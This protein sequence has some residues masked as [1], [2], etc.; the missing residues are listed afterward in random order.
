MKVANTGTQKYLT[1][2]KWNDI[3]IKTIEHI[4]PQKNGGYWD[5]ALYT[6]GSQLVQS[7]GNLTLLPTAINS[8][9]G[10]KNWSE[11]LLY[12]KHLNEK[13]PARLAELANKAAAQGSE[14]AESTIKL[15]QAVNYNEHIAPIVAVGDAD[16]NADW[17]ADLVERRTRRILEIMWD[18]VSE[19]I[20][21]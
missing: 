8:S 14:L 19:W 1:V 21:E 5:E 18:R 3:D 11:K 2:A 7:I 10:N 20:V 15:L 6:E 12:F 9:A 13:D 17:N 16:W 4:A